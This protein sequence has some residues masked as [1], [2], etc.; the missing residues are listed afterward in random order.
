MLRFYALLSILILVGCSNPIKPTDSEHINA[1]G[2]QILNH[3]NGDTLITQVNLETTGQLELNLTDI[4]Q[5]GVFLLD[6]NGDQ[7]PHDHEG[8]CD[9]ELTIE[10]TDPIATFTA[11]EEHMHFD[12]NGISAG[13]TTFTMILLHGDH[14]DFTSQPIDLVV[15]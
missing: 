12:I 10:L 15:Q 2:L 7:I 5:I 8:E 6:E 11:G 13:T 9:H 14:A 1:D 3:A 4:L